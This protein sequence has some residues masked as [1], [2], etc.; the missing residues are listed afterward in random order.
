V[1]RRR[2]RVV[3]ALV[4]VVD[5]ATGMRMAVDAFPI[6]IPQGGGDA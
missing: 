2:K 4:Y 6:W 3:T 1:E 5:D